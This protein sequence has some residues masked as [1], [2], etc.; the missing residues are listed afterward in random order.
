VV[1]ILKSTS[2]PVDR[3]LYISLEGME[4]IHVGWEGGALA[5]NAPDPKSLA[6]E[7]LKAKQITSLLVGLKSRAAVLHM[8]RFVETYP[9]EALSA[10][11][12]G[13]ALSRLWEMVGYAERALKVVSLFV[14]LVGLVS[15][16]IALYSTLAERRREMAILRSLGASAQKVFVLLISESLAL[17]FA[18]VVLGYLLV[19]VSI[20]V[21]RP[22]AEKEF[23]LYIVVKAPQLTELYYLSGVM[24]AAFVAGLLPAVKAYRNTLADGLSI[25]A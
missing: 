13:V 15:L 10:A 14:V 17:A 6:P 12:P 4:A 21:L 23:G 9:E 20:F 1:G 22:W 11:I 2:T 19:F 7:K 16:V 18:G 5:S 25:K 8:Q 24:L 3:A